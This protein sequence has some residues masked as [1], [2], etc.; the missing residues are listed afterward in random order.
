M[1][2]DDGLWRTSGVDG[3]RKPLPLAPLPQPAGISYPTCPACYQTIEQ[4]WLADWHVL[5]E[6][7]KS[8]PARGRTPAGEV[9][10]A[11]SERHPWTVVDIAM[12]LLTCPECGH[13]SGSRYQECTVC[14]LAFGQALA[15]EY[16]VTG[17]EHALHIGRWILRHPHQHSQNR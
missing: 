14:Y 16:G 9:V 11:E 12:T 13:E 8:S 10:M 15:S 5:L 6:R 3:G 17:N 1:N 4:F 7:D 2:H